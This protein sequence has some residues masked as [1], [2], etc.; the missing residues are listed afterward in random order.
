[1]FSANI[2]IHCFLNSVRI[3]V[4]ILQYVPLSMTYT[5]NILIVLVARSLKAFHS[6]VHAFTRTVPSAEHKSKDVDKY[7]YSM[8]FY[9]YIFYK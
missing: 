4:Q 2:K 8:L 5:P 3:G 6:E 7:W 1:M 9:L